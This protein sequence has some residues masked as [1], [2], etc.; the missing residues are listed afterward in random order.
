MALLSPPCSLF[1]HSIL[2]CWLQHWLPWLQSPPSGHP[3][4][5]WLSRCSLTH[6]RH[7]ELEMPERMPTF[8][9]HAAHRQPPGRSPGVLLAPSALLHA[10][11]RLQPTPEGTTGRSHVLLHLLSG[12][13]NM[14]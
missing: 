7:P 3:S 13:T 12:P 14:A 8:I 6:G 4:S 1:L 10:F 9:P 11:G 2:T 5:L